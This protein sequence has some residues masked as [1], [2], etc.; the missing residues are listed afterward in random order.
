[1]R[2]DAALS[3]IAVGALVM[4]S[5]SLEAQSGGLDDCSRWC[6]LAAGVCLG[7]VAI[8]VWL[9]HPSVQVVYA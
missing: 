9:L 1:M 7:L 6:A 5:M 3:T 4:L 8:G 2:F